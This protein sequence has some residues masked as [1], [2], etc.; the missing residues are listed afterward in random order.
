MAEVIGSPGA[1][2]DISEIAGYIA[3]DSLQYAEI[4]TRLFFSKVGMLE[5]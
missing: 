5:K 3:K 1:I 4:Q 2:K